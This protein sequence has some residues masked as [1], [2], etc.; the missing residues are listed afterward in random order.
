V[1]VQPVKGD[2]KQ[3]GEH[4]WHDGM[5]EYL[6]GQSVLLSPATSGGHA[7]LKMSAIP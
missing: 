3:G 2:A 7:R 5:T 1:L 6:H 4:A